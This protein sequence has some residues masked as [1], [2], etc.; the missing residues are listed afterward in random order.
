MVDPAVRSLSAIAQ[1][2]PM[3]AGGTVGNGK[4]IN[5]AALTVITPTE[6]PVAVAQET[7]NKLVGASLI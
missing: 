3:A 4:T 6:D 5:V 7:I 1:G 2:K